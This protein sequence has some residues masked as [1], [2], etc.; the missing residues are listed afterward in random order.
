MDAQGTEDRQ[1]V[2]VD[3]RFGTGNESTENDQCRHFAASPRAA[4]YLFQERL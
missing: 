4:G 3:L 2:G 1:Y